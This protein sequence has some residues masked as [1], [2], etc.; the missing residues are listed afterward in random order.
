[1]IETFDGITPR[2]AASAFV[3]PLALVRGDAQIGE[4]SIVH[5]GAVINADLAPIRIGNRVMIEDNCVI[6][7]GL[8][9]DWRRGVRTPLT[10]GDDVILGH[11]AVLHGRRIGDRV[12]I[13]M[14]ATVLQSAEIGDNCVIAA[15]AV[16]PEGEHIQPG[17]FVAGVPAKTRGRLSERQA[18]WTGEGID[19]AHVEAYFVVYIRKLRDASA[20]S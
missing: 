16:V 11:G 1:M 12:M 14:N 8:Y 5:A 9:E 2:I 13:G 15:G 20:Q 10:I 19:K 17:S 3:H 6:H 4:L 18:M 7:A